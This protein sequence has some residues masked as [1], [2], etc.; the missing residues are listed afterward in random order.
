MPTLRKRQH[1]LQEVMD[2]ARQHQRQENRETLPLPHHRMELSRL[3]QGVQNLRSARGLKME[4]EKPEIADVQKRVTLLEERL[5]N[6][7]SRVCII[8]KILKDAK[9]T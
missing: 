5:S 8:E 1:L 4:E 6:L 7:I 9:L 2:T 3:W